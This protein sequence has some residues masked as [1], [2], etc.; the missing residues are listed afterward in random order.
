MTGVATSHFSR[1]NRV[2]SEAFESGLRLDV[3]FCGVVGAL[4]LF[5]GNDDA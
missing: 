5:F 2:P 1:R 4:A 3:R